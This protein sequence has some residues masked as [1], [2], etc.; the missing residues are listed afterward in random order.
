MDVKRQLCLVDTTECVRKQPGNTPG[1]RFRCPLHS[2]IRHGRGCVDGPED[3]ECSSGYRMESGR[4]VPTDGIAEPGAGSQGAAAGRSWEAAPWAPGSGPAPE[5]DPSLM[6]HGDDLQREQDKVQNVG[7][8][9]TERR[10]SAIRMSVQ[11]TSRVVQDLGGEAEDPQDHVSAAMMDLVLLGTQLSIFLAF[12]RGVMY[13]WHTYL[14]ESKA[15]RSWWYAVRCGLARLL[16]GVAAE[17]REVSR[18]PSAA[19]SSMTPLMTSQEA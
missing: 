12:L 2:C 15:L 19:S 13:L 5:S 7:S 9:G 4:C 1:C 17:L 18:E 6:Q 8:F 14:G 11:S 10:G 16:A 3:C